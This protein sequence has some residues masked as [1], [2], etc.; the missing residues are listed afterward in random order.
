M[1]KTVKRPDK[2]EEES[3]WFQQRE[4]E[5]GLFAGVQVKGAIMGTLKC[6]NKTVYVGLSSAMMGPAPM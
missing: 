1:K 3:L 4:R 5:G 2:E 6:F